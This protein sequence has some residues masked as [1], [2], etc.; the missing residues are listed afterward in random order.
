MTIARGG[1][2]HYIGHR[3]GGRGS[4]PAASRTPRGCACTQPRNEMSLS[5]M[6]AR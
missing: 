6:G 5:L 2:D 3:S 4:R 1:G